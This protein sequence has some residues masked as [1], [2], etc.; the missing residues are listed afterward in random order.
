METKKRTTLKEIL[1]REK[2]QLSPGN[3]LFEQSI[4]RDEQILQLLEELYIV[5]K[6]VR[7]AQKDY[8]RHRK[9]S[10]LDRSKE[11]EKQLDSVLQKL[12]NFLKNDISGN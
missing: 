7:T 4:K 8:F 12:D 11:L 5:S 9:Q 6:Q 3:S 2:D 10:D 1:E